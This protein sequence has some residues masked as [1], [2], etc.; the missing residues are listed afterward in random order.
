VNALVISAAGVE[1]GAS[2]VSCA[3]SMIESKP[4]IPNRMEA[5][6]LA[7]NELLAAEDLVT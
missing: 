7:H 2:A 4:L 1:E 5:I 3:G 6:F